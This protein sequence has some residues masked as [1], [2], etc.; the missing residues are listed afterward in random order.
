L[1][2]SGTANDGRWFA[3]FGIVTLQRSAMSSVL[4][5]ASSWPLKTLPICSAV[6]RKN[7]SPV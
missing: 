1:N 3:P 2:V 5:R 7:W 6:F 4:R